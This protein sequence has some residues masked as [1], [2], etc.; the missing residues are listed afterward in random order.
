MSLFMTIIVLRGKHNPKIITDVSVQ[1]YAYEL[2]SVN[3]KQNKTYLLIQRA[4]TRSGVHCTAQKTKGFNPA[5][6]LDF[7]NVKVLRRAMCIGAATK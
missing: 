4:G 5:V 1:Q 6:T 3:V 7:Q 2:Q